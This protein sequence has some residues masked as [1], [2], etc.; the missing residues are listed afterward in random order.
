MGKYLHEKSNINY[1]SN[2]VFR[3]KITLINYLSIGKKG[4]KR[5][6]TNEAIQCY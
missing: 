3:A 2:P 6:S 1:I 4:K 5:N